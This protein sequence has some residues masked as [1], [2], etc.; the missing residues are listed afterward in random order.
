EWE[1]FARL[2]EFVQEVNPRKASNFVSQVN[3]RSLSEITEEYWPSMPRELE[4]LIRVFAQPSDW[5]PAKSWVEEHEN[6][7]ERLV[8]CLAVLMPE[9][10]TRRIESGCPLDLMTKS[11][12]GW[13]SAYLALASIEQVSPAV[14]K[15]LAERNQS[16]FS[17]GF[18]MLQALDSE[19]FPAF[20]EILEKVAPAV[21]QAALKNIDV[22]KAEAYW[23][24][25]LRGKT[26]HQRAAATL[27]AKVREAGGEQAAL[28]ERLYCRFPKA[29]TAYAHKGS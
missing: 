4:L 21:L 1:V 18:A 20:L 3:T 15:I 10:T 29:S 23:V 16:A 13:D 19:S 2:F 9:V 8:P 5:E 11:G 7:L 22:S 25:R 17:Q 27:L 14:A 6:V 12:S 24:D 28:A 26:V